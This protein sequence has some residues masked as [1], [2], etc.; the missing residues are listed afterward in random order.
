V[1]SLYRL[2]HGLRTVT[3]AIVPSVVGRLFGHVAPAHH[4][5]DND[6]VSAAKPRASFAG[7]WDGTVIPEAS[8]RCAMAD[9]ETPHHHDEVE[10]VSFAV[11]TISTS[12][13]LADDASG[14]AIV[15][16]I[17]D[18]GKRVA[19]RKVVTDDRDE[20]AATV[21]VLAD[22]EDVDAVVTTGGTGLSPTDVT[23]EAVRPL[24]DQEIPGFGEVF[25]SLSYDDVGPHAILSR[26]FAGTREEVPIFCLPGSEQAASFGTRELVLPTVGHMIEQLRSS[27]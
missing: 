23:P 2:P 6:R 16:L 24:F 4:F 26:A 3:V 27:G 25:R 19:S 11:L 10:T 13:D 5:L 8:D 17:E 14:D 1:I 9:H 18:D 22:R 20:I 12:R 7:I 15:D 21:E